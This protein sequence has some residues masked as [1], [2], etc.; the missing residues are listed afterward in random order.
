MQRPDTGRD[1]TLKCPYCE[2]E[3][4]SGE[5]YIESPML[6]FLVVGLSVLHLWFRSDANPKGEQVLSGWHDE[7]RAGHRCAACSAV[8]IKGKPPAKQSDA[9]HMERV[10]RNCGSVV[11]G[12]PKT[13]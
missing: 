9:T 11:T 12:N 8:F 2:G 4:V 1:E 3:M 13:C 10:C 5:A 6:A 7:S